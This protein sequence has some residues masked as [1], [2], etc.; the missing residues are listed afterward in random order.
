MGSITPNV[1]LITGIPIQKTIDQLIAVQSRPRDLLA[2]LGKKV[3]AEQI[4]IT[5]ISAS[6]LSFQFQAINVGK[7]DQFSQTSVTSSNA[8]LLSVTSTGNPSLGSFQFTPLQTAQSQQLLS[9]GLASDTEALGGGSFSFRFGGYIDSDTDLEILN[10]GAGVER[11]RIRITDRSGASAEIDLRF[12]RTV[13]DV[14][15]EVNK[16]AGINVKLEVRGDRFVLTDGTGDSGN[17]RVQELSGSTAAS[18]GLGG[19]N[20]AADEVVGQDV[21]Q[22]FDQLN[23]DLLNDGNGVRF[24]DALPELEI[25]FRDGSTPLIIDFRKLGNQGTQATATTTAVNGTDAEVEFTANTAGLDLNGVTIIFQDD[26]SVTA[27]SETV[28]YDENTQTL[29]FKIDEGNTTAN[30]II[31]ALNDDET[32]NAVF[33][34]ATPSGGAGTGLI[35][36]TDSALTAG[37]ID[38]IPNG[39]EQTLGDVLATLNAADPARLS[40]QISADGERI[41]ITDLTSDTGGTFSVTALFGTLAAADLGIDGAA[42]GDTLTGE[43]IF[44]GLNTTLLRN[45]NG[46]SGISDLGLL[47]LTDRSGAA[48]TIDLASVDTLQGVIDAINSAGVGIRAEVNDARNGIRLED[49]TGSTTSNL[50][51]ANGDVDKNTADKLGIAIDDAVDD[52]NSG[53]LSRRVISENTRLDSLNGGRGINRGRFQVTDTNG[54]SGTVDLQANSSIETIGDLIRQIDL[55]GLGLDVRVNDAGD[56]IVLIDTVEGGGIFQVS[57][58]SGTT[59]K[60]LQ[61]TSAAK[62]VQING[63]DKV[64]IDGSTTF[65]ITLGADESLDDLIEQINDIGAG[66]TA[67]KFSDG[68]TLTPFRLSLLSQQAGA[69]GAL[70]VDSSGLGFTVQ[71]TAA[72]QDALLLFGTT[73]VSGAGIVAS[74]STG[75]FNNVLPGVSVTITGVSEDPVTIN[76][77]KTS[78]SLTAGIIALVNTFNTLRD[79]ID[80]LTAFDDVELKAGLLLGDGNILRVETDLANLLSGRFFGV[81][82]IQS[83]KAV[84]IDLD[85]DG[86]LAF[87]QTVFDAALAADPEGVEEFF[88]K[89]NVGFSDKLTNLI[90]T[91]AGEETS[92]LSNRIDSLGTRLDDINRRIEFME[93][94]L[95]KSRELLLN[96]FNQLEL[97]IAKQQANLSALGALQIIPPL[98]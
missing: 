78:S 17:L 65:T 51:V 11:G 90:K 74:S 10:A 49:T 37:G 72:A 92:L 28:F 45:L 47:S 41:E 62:T 43:R 20:I 58:V 59:A 91:L 25:N 95:E 30:N 80:S 89:A 60:D 15:K 52:I 79:Q 14:L 96:S 38:P 29:T 55:L 33:T 84:G 57:D 19:V 97:A 5:A 56:G 71:E 36:A 39:D 31:D 87:D 67:S 61:L 44:S 82:S 75:T 98:T 85:G 73:D 26:P 53:S 93:E 7:S 32:A 9:S 13:D 81:G 48:T 1:G 50:I 3:E 8:S 64:V 22:L 21:F 77:Q 70:L 40:A 18:L 68:S 23:L 86:Q 94:R 24:D 63:E 66:V 69:S 27:G 83:L 12:V 76:V 2:L 34:A 88:T 54:S 16:A 42:V 35:D 6:L 4:A 46:L